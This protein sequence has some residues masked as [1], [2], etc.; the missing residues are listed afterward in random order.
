MGGRT[1]DAGLALDPAGRILVD[2][3]LRSVSRPGIYAVG[4]AAARARGRR[5]ARSGPAGRHRR[6]RQGAGG[7]LDSPRPA[8]GRPPPGPRRPP[9]GHGLMGDQN[10]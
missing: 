9:P 4:D 1:E 6:P 10:G 2:A 5:P 8:A 7:A 3:D